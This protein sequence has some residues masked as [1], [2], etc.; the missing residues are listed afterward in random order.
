[1]DLSKEWNNFDQELN[2]KGEH[3][4]LASIIIDAKSHHLI[5]ELFITY[6]LIRAWMMKNSRK[7]KMR[8]DYNES[9][10]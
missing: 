4:D 1:M 9:S 10:K 5:Q 8:I 3:I 2:H 7:I 6:E